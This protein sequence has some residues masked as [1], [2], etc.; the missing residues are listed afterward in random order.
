MCCHDTLFLFLLSLM[1][2]SPYP[3]LL[4]NTFPVDDITLYDFDNMIWLANS[5]I[6][7]TRFDAWFLWEKVVLHW[8]IVY[9]RVIELSNTSFKDVAMTYRKSDIRQHITHFKTCAAKCSLAVELMSQNAG[10]G[11]LFIECKICCTML[12]YVALCDTV[13]KQKWPQMPVHILQI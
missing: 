7:V 9:K 13:L 2:V 12:H 3:H 4:W 10:A 1:N 5:L 6:E 11:W 8:N